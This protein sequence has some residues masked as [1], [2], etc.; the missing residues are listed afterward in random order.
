MQATA[1]VMRTK[2]NGCSN[3]GQRE[4]KSKPSTLHYVN[5]IRRE[6]TQNNFTPSN[7]SI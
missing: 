4:S 7:K 6:E 1:T 5:K 3:L 2:D